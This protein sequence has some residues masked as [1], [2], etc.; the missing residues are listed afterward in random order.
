VALDQ[1]CWFAVGSKSRLFIAGSD[2]SSHSLVAA[3]LARQVKVGEKNQKILFLGG[4]KRRGNSLISQIGW[5]PLG[6]RQPATGGG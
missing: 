3:I 5:W 2:R 4:D 6:D 1:F